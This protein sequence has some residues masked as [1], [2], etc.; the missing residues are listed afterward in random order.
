M[1]IA[2]LKDELGRQA[3]D[4]PLAGGLRADLTIGIAARN[5]RRR[6]VSLLGTAAAVVVIAGGIGIVDAA[7]DDNSVQPVTPPGVVQVPEV[8]VA[9][10]TALVPLQLTTVSS[11]VS[12][13]IPDGLAGPAWRQSADRL[14]AIARATI[15]A[16]SPTPNNRDDL[17]LRRKWT[18]QKYRPGTK[19]LAPSTAAGNPISSVT[20]A[21]IQ[22]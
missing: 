14:T 21:S 10:G 16:S 2:D 3:A 22:P 19:V 12:V 15:E 8:E 11:P 20:A 5:R 1:N 9:P 6:T 7:R 18:P 13:K 17:R 4:S